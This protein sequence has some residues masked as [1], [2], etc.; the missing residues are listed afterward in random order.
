MMSQ[1]EHWENVFATKLETEV[2]WYQPSPK[3]SLDFISNLNISKEAKIIDIGGGDSYLVDALLERGFTNIT[4]LDIS[5]QAIERIKSRLGAKATIVTFIVSNI[6]DFNPTETY[7]LWHDR[8]SFHFQTDE[9]QIQKYADIVAKSVATNGNMI[10]GTFSE[11]GPKKCS[12]LDITQYNEATMNAVFAPNFEFLN[13]IT[14][15]H[16]TPFDTIQN[17]I[18]CS[19]K[20][21]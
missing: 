10:I 8:A 17:F 2:S 20:R 18:F 14:E 4:L 12:G 1:K 5:A 3:T 21:K 13:S 11:N 7:D 19:F 6:L 15:D 16:T 9:Q